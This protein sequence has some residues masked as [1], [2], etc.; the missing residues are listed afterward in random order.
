MATRNLPIL[1]ALLLSAALFYACGKKDIKPL[2][3]ADKVARTWQGSQLKLDIFLNGINIQ[4]LNSLPL[5]IPG[6]DL[7]TLK[8]LTQPFNIDTLTL[9]MRKDGTFSI[10][11]R[12]NPQTNEGQ[13]TLLENDTKL[14]LVLNNGASVISNPL[15]PATNTQDVNT[16]IIKTLDDK[17]MVLTNSTQQNVTVPNFPLPLSVRV[18]ANLSFKR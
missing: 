17:N 14:R 6:F 13:W 10:K 8:A 18:D 3:T 15:L 1:L 16:F 9:E 2:S 7:N 5:P 12:N 11:T 4:S